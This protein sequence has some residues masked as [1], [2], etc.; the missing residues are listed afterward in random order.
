MKLDKDYT[1]IWV[2]PET[3]ERIREREYR[4]S[5][6][7][8]PRCGH[9]HESTFTHGT[10][11]SG[12]WNRPSAWERYILGRHQEFIR[13]EDEDKIWGALKNGIEA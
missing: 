2:C 13:K 9:V 10:K 1:F 4:Y 7:V 12:R 5:E 6:G 8:C 3:N 11:V